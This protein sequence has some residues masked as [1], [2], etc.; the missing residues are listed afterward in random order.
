MASSSQI[1]ETLDFPL[2]LTFSSWEKRLTGR[3]LSLV[4]ESQGDRW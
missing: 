1:I 4:W 3:I 2:I